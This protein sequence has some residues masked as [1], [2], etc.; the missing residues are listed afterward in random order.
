M[1]AIGI[2]KGTEIFVFSLVKGD[3]S[4]DLSAIGD[5]RGRG[6]LRVGINAVHS[7]QQKISFVR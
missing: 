2:H 5:Q 1:M 7:K 4:M 6:I 3:F